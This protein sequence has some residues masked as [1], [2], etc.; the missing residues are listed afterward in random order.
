MMFFYGVFTTALFLVRDAE[1]QQQEQ[2]GADDLCRVYAT[3][4]ARR[5]TTAELKN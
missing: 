4:R 5:G 3:M 2:A 1:E